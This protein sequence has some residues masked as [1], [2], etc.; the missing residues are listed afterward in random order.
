MW[1]FGDFIETHLC[2]S[3]SDES[4]FC[5]PKHASSAPGQSFWFAAQGI[6]LFSGRQRV[7][8]PH[9]Q[10]ATSFYVHWKDLSFN[11]GVWE[12]SG[13]SQT[14]QIWATS[15]NG[16]IQELKSQ[17]RSLNPETWCGRT[18][19]EIPASLARG[20]PSLGRTGTL[21][22]QGRPAGPSC[23]IP[24]TP[25]PRWFQSESYLTEGSALGGK[26]ERHQHDATICNTFHVV[27][28][29]LL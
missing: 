11:I 29:I 2:L 1:S 23:R 3:H 25:T 5:P 18:E 7:T 13:V 10:Q 8:E 19:H 21:Q 20:C 24:A 16:Q 17:G 15:L 4:G 12:A 9:E 28:N 22:E 26:C 27:G 6:I 14:P